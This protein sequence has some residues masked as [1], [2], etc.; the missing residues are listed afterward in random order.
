MDPRDTLV[1]DSSGKE[2]TNSDH[3][4]TLRVPEGAIPEGVT[5]HIEAGV[6]LHGPFHFPPGARPISPIVW[7]CM[8]E[9][10]PFLKPVEVILPHF[11]HNLEG[12][13]LGLGLGF[14]KAEH[15]T[16][17]TDD[18][19]KRYMFQPV[20]DPF[21]FHFE[22]GR[23]FGV[24]YTKHFCSLCIQANITRDQLPSK[25]QYCLTEVIP[26]PW[27]SM[28]ISVPTHF[29]VTFFV[30]S[31]FQVSNYSIQYFMCVMINFMLQMLEKQFPS[32]VK[33][34]QRP[35]TFQT[36]EVDHSESKLQLDVDEPHSGWIVARKR[37]EVSSCYK[38]Y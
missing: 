17:T 29:C 4:I 2:F 27:P 31:C 23:G 15:S 19:E 1:C 28:Q 14:L 10:I 33:I 3:D 13:Q 5:V 35:F 20:N 6:A 18:D 9:K 8:Q 26:D 38:D 7:F 37:K 11:L 22:N 36:T 12:L 25:A 34:S 16:Y 32:K 30:N 21:E 24:L